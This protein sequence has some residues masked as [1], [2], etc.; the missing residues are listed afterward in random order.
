MTESSTINAPKTARP[1]QGFRGPGGSIGMPVEKAR[2][3]KKTLRRLA[4]YLKPWTLGLISVMIMAVFGTLSSTICPKIMGK[5]TTHLFSVFSKYGNSFAGKIDFAYIFSII[6]LL[7][8]LYCLSALLNYLQQIIMVRIVQKTVYRLRQDISKKF[9][10]LPLRYFDSHPHGDI[11]SR[12]VNDVDNIGNTLQQSI[13]Q[14]L[15]ALLTICG[16]IIM[17]LFISPLLTI[18][19]LTV[20]PL[21]IA[22]TK[23]IAKRSQNYFVQQQKAIGDLNG[24]VEEMF[25]GHIVVKSYLYE[26]KSCEKFSEI[27]ERLYQAGW[28]AQFISGIIMPVLMFINN[29]GYVM[30]CVV[31]GIFVTKQ[32]VTIG[33]V[34]AF[35]QYQR[36]FVHPLTQAASII[37]IIQSTIASA[38]RVFDFLDEEE[39]NALTSKESAQALHENVSFR[40][41]NFGYEKD[42]TLI[43]DMNLEVTQGHTIAIVGPTGA[44]KTTLV[45]LLMRFYDIDTG[46]IVIDG[47][48][49]R[50]ISRQNLRSMFGMVLQ[51]TW[52]FKGTIMENIAYGKPGATQEEV[53]AAATLAHADHFIRTLPEGYNFVINEEASNISQGQKQ[54]LTIARAVLADPKIL[55]LDEA[56][57]NVDSRTEVYIQEAMHR[58]MQNRTSFV[59]AHRLSTIRNADMIL[60][61]D[62]GKIIEKGRHDEL[63]HKQGFYADLYYSQYDQTSVAG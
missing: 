23:K 39:E 36:Q 40:H 28:K 55:I 35:I 24:H 5:I 49:T 25:T 34:Q 60:V 51:D 57:S 17:M 18:I 56:T 3:V 31:G 14:L 10:L 27:N 42:N 26:E 50:E 22:A 62:H 41:V 30:V 2:D 15:T 12:V 8:F 45:N 19:T 59:I 58:L 37:N 33:D 47:V 53:V 32:A 29:I 6:A 21:S 54:L 44:G 20:L 7:A 9:A 61:M 4:L 13:N 16:V 43:E 46:S 1:P 52:L 63:L 38:E 48:D 11:M